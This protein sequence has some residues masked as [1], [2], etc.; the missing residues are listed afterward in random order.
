MIKHHHYLNDKKLN[1]DDLKNLL[2]STPES[3]QMYKNSRS[4]AVL[5]FGAVII[6]SGFGLYGTA[7]SISSSL[8][9]IDNAANGINEQSDNSFLVP[10]LISAGLELTGIALLLNSSSQLKGSI[11]LYN[12]KYTTGCN[13]QRSLEFGLTANG[14]AITYHF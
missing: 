11:N 13:F 5:G 6:G 14:I 8:K 4:T 9:D 12:S 7:K 3:A 2:L 10:T 1:K